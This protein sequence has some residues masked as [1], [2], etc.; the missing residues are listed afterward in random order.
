[1]NDGRLPLYLQPGLGEL[2]DDGLGFAGVLGEVGD[3]LAV[4]GGGVAV[5]PGNWTTI[6]SRCSPQP[7]ASAAT[8]P[9]TSAWC[10]VRGGHWWT[11]TG[12]TTVISS[13][14]SLRTVIRSCHWPVKVNVAALAR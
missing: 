6:S 8:A 10:R 4:E 12:T 7:I 5:A 11:A 14:S 3:E 2:G 13:K 1:M 9:G